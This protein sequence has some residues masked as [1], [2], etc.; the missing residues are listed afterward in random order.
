MYAHE[1][2]LLVLVATPPLAIVA[3]NVFLYF[4]GDRDLM[5]PWPS[6]GYEPVATPQGRLI[7]NI[8]AEQQ[9]LREQQAE[10]EAAS[11]REAA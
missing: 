9:V 5:L 8:A 7:D 10:E 4:A 11:F 1:L 3:I 6:R 2:A